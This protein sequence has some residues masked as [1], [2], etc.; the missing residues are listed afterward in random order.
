MCFLCKPNTDTGLYQTPYLPH[1]A[2]RTLKKLEKE[3]GL[4]RNK[5]GQITVGHVPCEISKSLAFFHETWRYC[6]VLSD[7]QSTQT[8]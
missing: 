5:K 8:L 4:I 6:N 2:P 7:E 3:W 1:L